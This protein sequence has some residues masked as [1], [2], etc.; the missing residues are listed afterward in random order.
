MGMTLMADE[1]G[2]LLGRL[3]QGFNDITRRLDTQDR[4]T[5]T[6]KN[7]A[8]KKREEKEGRDEARFKVLDEKATI[9]GGRVSVL[10]KT[11]DE[12]VK[13]M[14]TWWH[15]EGAELPGRVSAL[16]QINSKAAA[17]K[18]TSDKLKAGEEGEKR[19]FFRTWGLIG[20]ALVAIGGILGWL[21]A[22][23]LSGILFAIA[24]RLGHG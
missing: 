2:R 10:E 23:K 20:G 16:E 22:D 13:P 6:N 3:E 5:E 24:V 11:M 1:V 18:I 9:T 12:D 15:D 4:T 14:V 17:D 21:G 19:G 8:I 7:E